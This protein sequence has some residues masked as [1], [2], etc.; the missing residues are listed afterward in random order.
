MSKIALISGGVVAGATIAIALYAT[1]SPSEV[2]VSFAG[3]DAESSQ[4]QSRFE[5]EKCYGVAKKGNNDCGV[6][7][8]HSCAGNAKVDSDPKE[9]LFLP[10]G[11]CE[12]LVGGSTTAGE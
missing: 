11:K 1:I 8:R 9:W 4:A 12:R 5:Q 7:G 10:K 6:P 2:V 3:K